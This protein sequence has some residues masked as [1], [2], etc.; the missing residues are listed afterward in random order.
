[1][2]IKNLKIDVRDVAITVMAI[3]LVVLTVLSLPQAAPSGFG[4]TGAP[5]TSTFGNVIALMNITA[6]NI[7][8]SSNLLAG[9]ATVLGNITAANVT[10]SNYLLAGNATVLGNFSAPNI[11][12]TSSLLAANLTVL[13]NA[14]YSG[15]INFTTNGTITSNATCLRY[16]SPAGTGVLEVCDT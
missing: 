7:T 2:D 10:S 16:L 9:N 1:M 8:S 5:S 14:T 11:T 15:L 6:P 13:G 12:S 4:F 3:W